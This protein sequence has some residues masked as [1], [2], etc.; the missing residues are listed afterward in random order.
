MQLSSLYNNQ[1][2]TKRFYTEGTSSGANVEFTQ[3]NRYVDMY[4]NKTDFDKSCVYTMCIDDS[5]NVVSKFN[6]SSYNVN[7]INIDIENVKYDNAV[8]FNSW[9]TTENISDFSLTNSVDMV[10]WLTL[11]TNLNIQ[12]FIIAPTIWAVDKNNLTFA[13]SNYNCVSSNDIQTVTLK[14]LYENKD[15]YIVIDFN[16]KSYYVT[17]N[18]YFLGLTTPYRVFFNNEKVVGGVLG[19]SN[20]T[21]F[22]NTKTGPFT[23][24]YG[25]KGTGST[26]VSWLRGNNFEDTTKNYIF[27]QLYPLE[28][29]NKKDDTVELV[30][31]DNGGWIVKH[32]SDSFACKCYWTADYVIK[33]F[34]SLGVYVLWD[35]SVPT[36][37]STALKDDLHVAI[38]EMNSNGF[39][40][41]KMLTPIEKITSETPNLNYGLFTDSNADPDKY[42]PIKPT[43]DDIT[44][45][46]YR[47]TDQIG[48]F[49]MYYKVNQSDLLSI[50]QRVNFPSS[51]HPI[52]DGWEFLP[53]LVSCT[54]YPYNVAN[55]A[56]GGHA[57]NV[58]IGSWD[59]GVNAFVLTSSQF[60]VQTI[61]NFTLEHRFNNF[62]DYLPYAQYQ[63]YIPLCGWVDLPD[64]C[65]AKNITV[66][67]ATDVINNSCVAT[68]KADG[69]PIVS[70]VGHMGSSIAISA[71]EN[72]LKQAALTQSLFNTL[73]AATSTGYAIAT[74][75]AIGIVNGVASVAGAISQGNIANN[76]NYTRQVGATSDKSDFHVSNSCYLKISY[77]QPDETSNYAHTIGYPCNMSGT[78]DDF[79]GYTVCSDV[80]VSGLSCTQ[81]QKD[82]IK[83]TLETGFY[84]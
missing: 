78:V 27:T 43:A 38:G 13:G 64:V 26:E 28:I 73:G 57:S 44:E 59:S 72:G 70:K 4:T 34:A 51:E 40:T 18:R 3:S 35:G 10:G 49:T 55:Y 61:A 54:Q 1:S 33:L 14:D 50:V 80:D 16:V 21:G 53:H 68:V 48:G 30:T 23:A 84:I 5:M 76:S 52:P 81:N 77:T 66:E 65:V 31:H 37:T 42:K 58:I 24:S 6:R 71:T 47:V 19:C 39:T 56:S 60:A 9:N 32:G 17:N 79:S 74:Q 41:G 82:I 63:L 75:N 22:I 45:P 7:Q 20:G 8:I 25:K 11:L 83:R 2:S 15:R 69:C 62:L 12:N 67:L 29:E 36:S 46:E